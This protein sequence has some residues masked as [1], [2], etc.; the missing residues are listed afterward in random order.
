MKRTSPPHLK[1]LRNCAVNLRATSHKKSRSKPLFTRHYTRS[2]MEEKESMSA[3][4]LCHLLNQVRER[5]N[6]ARGCQQH[7]RQLPLGNPN[8]RLSSQSLEQS[9]L[10]RL[11]DLNVTYPKLVVR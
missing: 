11:L 1:S 6:L 2:P 4:Y 5:T 3:E 9:L 7:P 10:S 8:S